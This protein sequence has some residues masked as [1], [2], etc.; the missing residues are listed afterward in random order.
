MAIARS[1]KA[2]NLRRTSFRNP[3]PDIVGPP[4]PRFAAT[5][6]EKRPYR[7]FC[8]KIT[9]GHTPATQV[10]HRTPKGLTSRLENCKLVYARPGRQ[11]AAARRV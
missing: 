5:V 6:E 3:L 10:D 7:A 11:W 2:Y 8:V 4:S 9:T 1:A